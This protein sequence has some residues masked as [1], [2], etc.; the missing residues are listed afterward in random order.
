MA[1]Q[2]KG[3]AH[4]SGGALSRGPLAGVKVVV[5]GV[6]FTAARTGTYLSVFGA[7]TVRVDSHRRPDILRFQGPFP[8]GNAS[9]SESVWYANVNSNMLGL[10]LDWTRPSG[11]AIMDR[12]LRWADVVIEN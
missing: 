4:K 11:K 12:L 1:Y 7:T 8:G 5:L 9:L 3:K 2:E 6:A 10:S